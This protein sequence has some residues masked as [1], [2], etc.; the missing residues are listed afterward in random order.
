MS[1]KD[2][3]QCGEATRLIFPCSGSADV[4]KIADPIADKAL[5]CYRCGTSTF[6]P[7][8]GGSSSTRRRGR[9]MKRACRL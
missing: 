9:P 6:E 8:S 4:G 2:E 3:C 1:T 7:P 5:I